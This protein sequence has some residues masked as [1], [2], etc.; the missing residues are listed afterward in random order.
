MC[1]Y[2]YI[3]EKNCYLYQFGVRNRMINFKV[4]NAE[5]VNFNSFCHDTEIIRK[6]VVIL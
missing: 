4:F 5:S 1:D 6:K 3:N 2:S